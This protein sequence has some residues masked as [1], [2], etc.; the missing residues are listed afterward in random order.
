MRI[1]AVGV[2]ALTFWACAVP[3]SAAP[4]G[5][6]PVPDAVIVPPAPLPPPPPPPPC[7]RIV[8]IEIRKSERTLRAHC[9]RGAVVEMTAAMGREPTGHKLEFGDLRTPEG[10][11]RIS[12]PAEAS[13]FH[14]FVPIDY[15]SVADA[16]RALA[17]GRIRA[18]DHARIVSAHQ[19]DETPPADTVM[20][21]KI[22]LHGEGSRWAGDSVQLDWTYGCVAVSDRDL[23]FLIARIEPGVRVEILP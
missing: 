18:A 1:V 10:Q 7:E 21:G 3:P 13:R 4:E 2:F 20:G 14:A 12:G 23:D 16:D 15:P 9:E 22:G 6:A 8:R 5:P 11:Y 17:E 19:R